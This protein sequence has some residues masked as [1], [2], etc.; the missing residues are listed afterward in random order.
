MPDLRCWL[1]LSSRGW[2]LHAVPCWHLLQQGWLRYMHQV[3]RR[4]H[5]PCCRRHHPH[6]MSQGP[7]LRGWPEVLHPV[8]RQYLRCE[9]WHCQRLHCLPCWQGHQQQDGLHHLGCL[10]HQEVVSPSS[11][12]V[13]R[14][15]APHGI[16]NHLNPLITLKRLQNEPLPIMLEPR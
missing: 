10:C 11:G 7:V 9:H 15:G 2:L 12:V 4:L 6:S 16:L 14:G 8:P 13:C 5:V 1:L 3:Y